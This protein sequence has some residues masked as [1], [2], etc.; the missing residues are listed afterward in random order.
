MIGLF[1]QRLHHVPPGIGGEVFVVEDLQDLLVDDVHLLDI[2]GDPPRVLLPST[3][4][5]LALQNL[6]YVF[7][8]FFVQFPVFGL[9][10]PLGL[11]EDVVDH[12]RVRNGEHQALAP[13]EAAIL[14]A[15]EILLLLEV[16]RAAGPQV[17][18]LFLLGFLLVGLFEDHLG[19]LL[20]DEVLSLISLQARFFL[21]IFLERLGLF[22][23]PLS[24]A[25]IL[26]LL[27]FPIQTAVLLRGLHVGLLTLSGQILN[28]LL[29]VIAGLLRDDRLFLL[30]Q[31]VVFLRLELVAE[32]V[33]GVVENAVDVDGSLVL[34]SLPE[35]LVVRLSG[36][37]AEE[38][39]KAF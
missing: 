22:G 15:L 16:E 36:N 17:S 11:V 28:A 31:G 8:D 39:Q 23:R 20:F 1:L 38:P 4:L 9:L 13:L 7:A 2:V 12:K 21:C 14:P 24:L 37:E 30:G 6:A 26:L 3:A 25:L 27:A 29:L 34:S 18:L 33:E 10:G 5:V 35:E 19:V 32:D